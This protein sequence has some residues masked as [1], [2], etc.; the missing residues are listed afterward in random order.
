MGLEFVILPC[1]ALGLTVPPFAQAP[2]DREPG[3]E[4]ARVWRAHGRTRLGGTGKL[5]PGAHPRSPM[6][7]G[8]GSWG[9]ASCRQAGTWHVEGKEEVLLVC[10]REGRRQAAGGAGRPRGKDLATGVT[11]AVGGLSVEDRVC[12]LGR[13]LWFPVRRMGRKGTGG[14]GGP[15]SRGARSSGPGRRVGGRRAGD[16]GRHEDRPGCVEAGRFPRRPE[17]AAPVGRVGRGPCGQ[18]YKWV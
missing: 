8:G 12:V 18:L 7:G 14:G 16:F 11:G 6:K 17:F 3:R 10:G 2:G 5:A 15:L 1:P 13:S 9:G 4:R